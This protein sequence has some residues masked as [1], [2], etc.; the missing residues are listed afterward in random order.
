MCPKCGCEDVYET[1]Y[2]V[3][4]CR[5]VNIIYDDDWDIIEDEIHCDDPELI[6]YE[7]Y[8]CDYVYISTDIEGVIDEMIYYEEF[9][10]KIGK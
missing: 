10:N 2:G 4:V 8:G 7:C 1:L 6:K 3:T 9:K 5:R